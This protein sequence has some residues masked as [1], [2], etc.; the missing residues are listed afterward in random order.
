V[1]EERPG[2]RGVFA[3]PR[4]R[5]T[6][7][8]DWLQAVR[9]CVVGASGY[10]VNLVVFALLVTTVDLH[11]AVAATAAFVVAVT[12]NFCLNRLWT[13]QGHGGHAGVQGVRYLAVSVAALVMNLLLL[14]A[15][16][17]LSVPEITAQAIAVL[18]V[19]PFNFLANRRWTFVP[20]PPAA[21]AGPPADGEGWVGPPRRT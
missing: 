19:T 8:E 2:P 1:N 12:N 17:A 11:H 21:D 15:L 9:F 14:E 3:L 10:V 13:F 4:L 16:I 6:T 7:R 5:R 18:V 20:P